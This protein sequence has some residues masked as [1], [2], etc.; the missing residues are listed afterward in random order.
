MESLGFMEENKMQINSVGYG[1]YENQLKK[2]DSTSAKMPV[3]DP[4]SDAVEKVDQISEGELLGMTML[5]ED[6]ES[7][8]YGM[9]AK[10]S[11]ESTPDKPIVQ[12]I[13]N[14]NGE[15]E[16]FN[17]DINSV[18]PKNASRME[19]FALCC[20]EDKIGRGTSSTFGSYHTFRM[21]EETAK[22]NGFYRNKN[23]NVSAWEQFNN[24]KL[25]WFQICEEVCDYLKDSKDAK[26]LD[27][28]LKGRQ[29]LE[30]YARYTKDK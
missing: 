28:W 10:L 24:E 15:E 19:M 16:I 27:L 23:E 30:L 3:A 29:L 26:I 9:S 22:Q 5:P 2:K 14:I 4:F 25:D 18:D 20:Y 13:S 11:C 7:T 12:V 21:Y 1:N 8:V 6:G 17:V